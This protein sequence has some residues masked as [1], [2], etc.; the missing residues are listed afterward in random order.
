[1]AYVYLVGADHT[2]IVGDKLW[3]IEK[4]NTADGSR[5]WAKTTASP[6]SSNNSALRAT[7]QNNYLYVVGVQGDFPTLGWGI[8]TIKKYDLDGNE[9]WSVQPLTYAG[10]YPTQI[11]SDSNGIYI[12][13]NYRGTGKNKRGFVAKLDFDGNLVWEESDLFYSY[14]VLWAEN[15]AIDSS[16]LY[17]VGEDNNT[18][19]WNVVKIDFNHSELWKI[20]TTP[21]DYSYPYAVS[22]YGDYVYIAGQIYNDVDPYYF[23]WMVERRSI[24]DG[25]QDWVASLFNGTWTDACTPWSMKVNSNGV[26]TVGRG[27]TGLFY[28][29]KR[30]LSDGSLSWSQS[31]SQY[32]YQCIDIDSSNIY[33]SGGE[34]VSGEMC[35]AF[36]K[37]TQSNGTLSY[38]I[39]TCE[40]NHYA[41][42]YGCLAG[43][44]SPYPP[45]DPIDDNPDTLPDPGGDPQEITFRWETY[46]AIRS[47]RELKGL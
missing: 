33:C 37:R 8:F 16:G 23:Y 47:G 43:I 44:T 17:V 46:K 2:Q 31:D 12:A 29:E 14:G 42:A 38:F 26:F 10:G 7:I 4:R 40:Y 11:V 3:V 19:S 39:S 28:L 18:L 32:C 45:A 41:W 25:T 6:G 36:E 24:N 27:T 22:V 5:V 30:V 15:L 21:G 34:W 35:Y 9:Q 1:M 13:G 20:T